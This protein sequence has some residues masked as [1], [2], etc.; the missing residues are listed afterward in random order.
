MKQK[1]ILTLYK[2]RFWLLFVIAI[3]FGILYHTQLQTLTFSTTTE[4]EQME[5]LE[6]MKAVTSLSVFASDGCSGGISTSWNTAMANYD[7]TIGL[8]SSNYAD[9][10][11][12]PFESACITHDKAYHQG[13]GGYTARLQADRQFRADI[14]EYGITN[15][16][17]IQERAN[18]ASPEHAV[19]LYEFI[20][21]TVYR[22]VRLGG[23]PCTGEAYAWGYGYGAGSCEFAA[24]SVPHE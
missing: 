15:A 21:D 16:A 13:V 10:T 2:K 7:S 4:Q 14:I 5:Q 11:I 23:A 20:A 18:L 19:R 17:D 22:G 3:S 8:V 9:V 12:L 24:L 1:F 6:A